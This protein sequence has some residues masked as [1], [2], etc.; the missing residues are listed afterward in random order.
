[1]SIGISGL[2]YALPEGN[3]THK[4]LQDR[5]GH[6]EM[7]R[8]IK[9]TGIIN[10]RVCLNNECASDLAFNAAK[11][12]I[13]NNNIDPASIDLVLF[14]SQMPD[15]LMPTTACILQD[16]LGIPSQAGAYDINLGCSQYL[17][18]HA[19]AYAMIKSGLAK[20]VLVMSADTPSRIVNKMDRSV[21]PLFGDAGT[22]AIIEN[23]ENGSGYQD[24]YFGSDGS[25]H[26]SLIW[27]SSGLRKRHNKE[28]SIEVKDK[29]GS[30]RS[31]DDMYMDGQKIFIFTLKTVPSTVRSFLEKNNQKIEEIDYF[32]FHQASELI[33]NTITKK[34]KVPDDKFNRIYKNR[35]N[36]GGS[37][38]GIALHDAIQ[39]GKI[40]KNS[41]VL[42]SAFGV[43]LSWCHAIYNFKETI[44]NSYKID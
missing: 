18:S 17:Y 16:R 31:D 23:V 21:V 8:L 34:L 1:M 38:V 30:I 27:P 4:E 39:N 32:I 20:K 33:L 25:E 14:S 28:T 7:D 3:L 2:S 12:L 44:P 42:L 10:R 43:G 29:L 36:S 9:N 37:T 26:D 11:K 5:F 22:A 41:K 6:D 19:N 40:K 15:Y 24:F 13:D 35:G